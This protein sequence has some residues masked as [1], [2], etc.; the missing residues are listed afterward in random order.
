M[1]TSLTTTYAGA[2]ALPY[3]S[4]A[5][6][7]LNSLS[8][9][10]LTVKQN[11]AGK[12]VVKTATVTGSLKGETCDWSDPSTITIAERV[13]DP[14]AMEIATSVCKTDFLGDW[15]VERMGNSAWKSMGSTGLVQWLVPQLLAGGM[16][17]L[18]TMIW[19]GVAGANAFDGFE[20]LFTA[21][22][23]V[24]D[25]TGT[26]VTAAN[27]ITELGKVKAAMS[28]AIKMQPDAKIIV[29]YNVFE[30]YR[31]ALGGFNA[32]GLGANGVNGRGPLFNET[33]LTFGGIPVIAANGLADDSMVGSYTSNLWFGTNLLSDTTQIKTLDMEQNDLSNNVRFK[34]K[35]HAAVQ[36]GAGSE[37]VYY[38]S[39]A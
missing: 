27:V 20:T 37:V 30:A 21:D 22:A 12:Q 33:N 7:Q 35:F 15:E 28:N 3:F 8:N 31:D 34:A 6:L 16:A 36:Y 13:L 1:A 38:K 5:L 26:A 39:A 24:T 11:I 25:V 18:E 23:T 19:Q 32:N 2:L 10:A 29:A 4:P 14:K 9:G 17:S